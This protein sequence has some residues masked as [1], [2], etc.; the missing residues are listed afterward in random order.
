MALRLQLFPNAKPCGASGWRS[1]GDPGPIAFICG[2][3]GGCRRVQNM[4]SKGA[5]RVRLGRPRPSK[6]PRSPPQ[7]TGFISMWSAA[8]PRRPYLAAAAAAALQARAPRAPSPPFPARRPRLC[9]A[10][11]RARSQQGG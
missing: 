10:R 5:S 11:R 6:P 1:G 3:V 2:G 7:L 4:G 9:L 8:R